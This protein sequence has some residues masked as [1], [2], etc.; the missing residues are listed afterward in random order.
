MA[1]SHI[2][3]AMVR[4]IGSPHNLIGGNLVVLAAIL[5]IVILA[6]GSEVADR[7]PQNSSTRSLL[8]GPYKPNLYFG[9]RPRIP[10]SLTAGL[11]WSGL[12]SYEHFQNSMNVYINQL[13]TLHLRSL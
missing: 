8:W 6:A 7:A 5:G 2:F 3:L 11:L 10:K 1:A 13:V 9:V 12:D 4:T